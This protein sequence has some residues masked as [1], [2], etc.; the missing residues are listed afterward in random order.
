MI[1]RRSGNNHF[2]SFLT[3]LPINEHNAQIETGYQNGGN[4]FEDYLQHYFVHLSII[5]EEKRREYSTSTVFKK[6][7]S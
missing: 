5:E 6:R 4:E 1:A 2:P 3:R 7:Y